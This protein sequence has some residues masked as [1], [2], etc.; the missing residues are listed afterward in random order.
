MSVSVSVCSS[1]PTQTANLDLFTPHFINAKR[2][3]TKRPPG[4]VFLNRKENKLDKHKD[5]ADKWTA[6]L[7]DDENALDVGNKV[8]GKGKVVPVL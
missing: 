1:V 6:T 4:R 2:K 5:D 7:W 8:K 3:G